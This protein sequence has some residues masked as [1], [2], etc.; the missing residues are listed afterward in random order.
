M[1]ACPACE[2]AKTQP[3]TALTRAACRGCAIRE[4]ARSPL[5][6]QASMLESWRG[7]DYREA[8]AQVFGDAWRDGH[9][10]VKKERARQ[11]DAAGVT[12]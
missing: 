11:K 2:K 6:H 3:L 1:N 7:A 8:L 12:L 9:E 4:L 5:Y 10:L